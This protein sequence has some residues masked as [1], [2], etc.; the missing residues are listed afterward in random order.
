MLHM[1]SMI[2]AEFAGLKSVNK[3]ELICAQEEVVT[4]K[5]IHFGENPFSFFKYVFDLDQSL[6][7]LSVSLGL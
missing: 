5:D 3:K 7:K 2:L 4:I 1:F 6:F